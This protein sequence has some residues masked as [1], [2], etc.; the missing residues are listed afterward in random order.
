MFRRF[1]E[2]DP[3]RAD[4]S[5]QAGFLSMQVCGSDRGIGR[6]TDDVIRL[7]RDFESDAPEGE[8]RQRSFG[9]IVSPPT[10]DR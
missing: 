8:R 10:E 1:A 2:R 6:L 5:D 4:G 9:I 3:G 7:V